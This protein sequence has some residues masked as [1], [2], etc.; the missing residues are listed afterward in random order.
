M[1]SSRLL[2][3]IDASVFASFGVWG[4]I[5]PAS[6]LSDLGVAL[7]TPQALTEIR[8]MYGGFELGF[9]AFLGAS[10]ISR[11]PVS[12]GSLLAAACTLS[13]FGLARLLGLCIDRS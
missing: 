6:M 12:R 10:A 2:L 3:L 13:G 9:A 11:A 7:T 5:A 1:N 4:L 8:A